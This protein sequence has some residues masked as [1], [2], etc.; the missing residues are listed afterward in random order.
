MVHPGPGSPAMVSGGNCTCNDPFLDELATTYLE[1]LP[2]IANVLKRN[3]EFAE[4]TL[5]FP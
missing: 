5:T 3:F 2:I 4:S 1:A